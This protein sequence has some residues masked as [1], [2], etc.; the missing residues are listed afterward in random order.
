MPWLCGKISARQLHQLCATSPVSAS[1]SSPP[2]SHLFEFDSPAHCTL[3]HFYHSLSEMLFSLSLVAC[4][5]FVVP[6]SH[7]SV[8]FGPCSHCIQLEHTIFFL[9]SRPPHFFSCFS[10]MFDAYF[11]RQFLFVQLSFADG[12]SWC[13][14]LTFVG[15]STTHLAASP[16]H[17]STCFALLCSFISRIRAIRSCT[18]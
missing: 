2:A 17:C 12:V 5:V 13:S 15:V 6:K 1:C 18:T 3:T 7:A 14:G 8:L 4:D 11:F 16:F 10:N 9:F